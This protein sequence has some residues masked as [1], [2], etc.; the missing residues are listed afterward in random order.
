M[1]QNVEN[2]YKKKCLFVYEKSKNVEKLLDL[3]SKKNVE[4]IPIVSEEKKVVDYFSLQDFSISKLKKNDTN[5]EVVIMAGGEGSRL[6]PLTN[7]VPKPLI[8]LQDK[9]VIEKI[10]HKFIEQGFKN[11]YLSIN[12]KKD[13]IKK[14]FKNLNLKLNLKYL[15]EKKN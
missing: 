14:F 7:T 15:E 1:N 8:P 9:T 4:V 5:L 13:V 6:K 11:F 10:I 2:I 12:Y 3:C